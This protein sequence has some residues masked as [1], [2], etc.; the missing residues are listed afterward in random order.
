[1]QSKEKQLV[2]FDFDGVIINTLPFQFELNRELNPHITYEV[3]KDM[4]NG[5]FFDSFQGEN[6]IVKLTPHP[7][8]RKV[9]RDKV[10]EFDTPLPIQN[11]IK[12]FSE[13]YIVAIVSSGSEEAIEH[14][15]GKKDLNS[16]FNDILGHETDKSKVVKIKLLLEKYSIAEKDAVFITDTLGDIR[17]GNEVGIKSIGVTW[18]LHDRETLEKGSPVT[19]IDDPVVLEKTVETILNS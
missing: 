3:Y 8:Y 19:V 13:K 4:S 16:Y 17:E 1:M 15:L 11:A 18:G 2:I 14:F 7:Q 5:N 6:A 10:R 9:Y 12:K